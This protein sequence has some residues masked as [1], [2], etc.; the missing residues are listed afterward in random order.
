MKQYFTSKRVVELDVYAEAKYTA[1]KEVFENEKRVQYEGA[2]AFE[3]LSGEKAEAYE[4]LLGD[5]MDD[6]KDMIDDYH[7]YLVIYFDDCT[8]LTY[9]NSY[10]DMFSF[11][12]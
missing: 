3:V 12:M 8:T 2:I 7:E 10:V 9:K 4:K 11:P 6:M 5:D 1:S